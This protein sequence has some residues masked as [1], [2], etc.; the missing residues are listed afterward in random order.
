MDPP[1]H[2]SSANKE[3]TDNDFLLEKTLEHMA[4]KKPL[5]FNWLLEYEGIVN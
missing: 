3:V 2:L 4:F 5:I 1:Y